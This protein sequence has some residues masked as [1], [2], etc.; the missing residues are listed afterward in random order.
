M[1]TVPE[2]G[3]QAA[4]DEQPPADRVGGRRASRLMLS[5][6]VVLLRKLWAVMVCVL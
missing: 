5:V 1:L 4:G 3:V 6:V 2:M